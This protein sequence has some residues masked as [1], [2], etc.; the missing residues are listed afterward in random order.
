V[1]L[2]V[3]DGSGERHEKRFRFRV[4]EYLALKDE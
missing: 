2:V 1:K 4:D 3:V